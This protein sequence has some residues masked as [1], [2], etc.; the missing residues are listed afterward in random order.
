V[1]G[2]SLATHRPLLCGGPHLLRAA[3][4]HRHKTA[5]GDMMGLTTY[6][7]LLRQCKLL[8]NKFI[9]SDADVLFTKMDA[10]HNDGYIHFQQFKNL[11]KH[12][13]A[14]KFKKEALEAA[15]LKV[16]GAPGV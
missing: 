7:K 11:L 9:L 1:A 2:P 14:Y 4:P 10:E 15:H 6:H 13:G 8:D 16:R 12:I 5:H 3:I